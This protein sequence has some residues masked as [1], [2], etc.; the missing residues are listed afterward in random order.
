[1]YKVGCPWL[2]ERL[3]AKGGDI[4]PGTG[5]CN[6]GASCTSI[7]APKTSFRSPSDNSFQGL[8]ATEY[9]IYHF[10][11]RISLQSNPTPRLFPP[12][13][14]NSQILVALPSSHFLYSD[15]NCVFDLEAVVPEQSFASIHLGL[16]PAL[17]CT[18]SA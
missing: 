6:N 8:P 1:M 2:D 14:S 12:Q 11:A 3:F 18:P 7:L 10:P 15:R 5:R 16:F 9:R 4:F 17:M 13:A